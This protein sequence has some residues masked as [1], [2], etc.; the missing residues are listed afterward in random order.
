[1][2]KK[3]NLETWKKFIS[4]KR[5][6]KFREFS[7]G[8][9]TPFLI[10]DLKRIKEKY[11]ELHRLMPRSKI[12]YAVK[13]CP[14]NEIIKIL[15]ESGSN[16]DVASIN[17][18]NQVM[19]LGIPASKLSFG[20]TIKKERDIAYAYQKGV[21]LFTTDSLSDI[22]KLAKKAPNSNV[23]FRILIEGNGADWPLSRKFGAH[24]D[25]I[26]KLIKES[27]SLSLRPYGLSFHVGSQ[28][29]DI[30]KWDSAIA[31]CRY[32]FD[33]LKL[34]GI[35]LKAINIGGGFPTRYIRPTSSIRNYTKLIKEYLK[36][37]FG[38]DKLDILIEPGRSLTGD[39]GIIFS[40]V[41]LVSKKSETQDVRWV[42][43]DVGKF[44]GLIETLDESIKYPIYVEGKENE[45]KISEVILA[46]PTCD[47]YDILY[48][49]FKYKL[50]D[51]L[52]DGDR[53]NILST[54]AYTMSY[55]SVGFNGFPPLKVY[56]IN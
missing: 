42:Y 52:R 13:A 49:N 1:M 7:K 3:K 40:E 33:A 37:D 31:M 9:Q 16:F 56:V 53:V 29:R 18:I 6:Q 54:G 35:K 15:H 43:L 28:Q 11:E 8:K 47:S 21:R 17:E 19:K 30:G 2:I 26:Y 27:K 36:E 5:L 39:A 44:G 23:V 34:D 12:Y 41:V 4:E 25:L 10:I 14:L 51:N 48:E 46:G 32:L 38:T 55:S 20:N 50:P 24:P 22:H 45:I